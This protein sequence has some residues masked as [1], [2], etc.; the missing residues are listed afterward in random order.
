MKALRNLMLVAV[1][2]GTMTMMGARSFAGV[3]PPLPSVW[4]PG[5]YVGG[6]SHLASSKVVGSY[7]SVD[8]WVFFDGTTYYY[9]YQLE[10]PSTEEIEQFTVVFGP[11]PLTTAGQIE[12]VTA[13]GDTFD[14]AT[15]APVPAHSITG[16]TYEP[17]TYV[18]APAGNVSVSSTGVTFTDIDE[19]NDPVGLGPGKQNNYVFV[20]TD[21]RPPMYG[22]GEALD[23]AIGPWGSGW[24]YIDPDGPGPQ[25]GVWQFGDP[26]PVPSPEPTLALLLVTGLAG[27]G[28]L[29]RKRK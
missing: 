9:F 11:H 4:T 19:T 17:D 7:I 16:E 15:T 22:S 3:L 23:G 29:R 28:F 13:F 18:N 25:P 14:A 6:E 26:I 5:Q 21:P 8:W 10:N 20:I 24:K 1:V 12:W 27:I 2:V